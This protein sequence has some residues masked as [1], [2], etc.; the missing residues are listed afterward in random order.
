MPVVK[1]AFA[2]FFGCCRHSSLSRVFTL[3][4]R[5]YRVCCKCGAEFDYSLETM[6]FEQHCPDTLSYLDPT[7][8]QARLYREYVS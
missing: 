5:S 7:T 3:G 8:G 4:G 2:F 6:S 1:A